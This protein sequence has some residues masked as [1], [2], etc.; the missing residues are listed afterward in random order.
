MQAAVNFSN[1]LFE[2]AKPLQVLVIGRMTFLQFD[3]FVG[4]R[5]K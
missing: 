3:R 4:L 2:K 1:L 5:A